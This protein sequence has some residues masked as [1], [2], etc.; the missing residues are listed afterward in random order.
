MKKE[1]IYCEHCQT[2]TKY[3]ID[4]FARWHLKREHNMTM[5]EYYDL[6]MKK[7]NE[8]KCKMC[9]KE[10]FWENSTKGYCNYCSQECMRKD[11]DFKELHK[12]S[13][14][15]YDKKLADKRRRIYQR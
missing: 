9:G 6:Y 10:C 4:N 12:K 2:Q 7:E 13:V 3:V 14:N 1:K 11:P 15:S 8:E 5:K